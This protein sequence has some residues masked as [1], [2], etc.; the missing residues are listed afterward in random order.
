[1]KSGARVVVV[2]EAKGACST[3][4]EDGL[5][6]NPISPFGVRVSRGDDYLSQKRK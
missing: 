1:M 3:S 2:I 5:D 4:L 6:W